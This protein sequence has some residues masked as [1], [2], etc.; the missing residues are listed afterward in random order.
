MKKSNF[1]EYSETFFNTLPE[2][3]NFDDIVKGFKIYYYD[4][5]QEDKNTQIHGKS[6]LLQ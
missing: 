2:R 4:S 6:A 5:L 3:D 1:D